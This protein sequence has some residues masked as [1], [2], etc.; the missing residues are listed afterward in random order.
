[1]TAPILHCLHEPSA[2]VYIRTR[3]LY[4]TKAHAQA[5]SHHYGVLIQPF[6]LMPIPHHVHTPSQD[7][8]QE[9]SILRAHSEHA[10]SYRPIP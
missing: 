7:T 5:Q 8:Q 2:Q 9:P 10:N 1:M 4:H 3:T 6:C